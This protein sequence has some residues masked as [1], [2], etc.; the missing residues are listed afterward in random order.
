MGS[1]GRCAH[2]DVPLQ[3]APSEVVGQSGEQYC[4]TGCATL[5]TRLRDQSRE[6]QRLKG[7]VERDSVTGAASKTQLAVVW[8]QVLAYGNP[9]LL[10]LDIDHF[11]Q[12]NDAWGHLVGDEVLSRV[13]LRI[14]GALRPQ[15]A[16]VRYGGDE[17]VVLLANV[18]VREAEMVGER[19]RRTVALNPIAGPN[20]AASVTLSI[21]LAAFPN[22]RA[23]GKCLA[24]WL[25]AADDALYLAKANGRNRVVVAVDPWRSETAARRHG[26]VGDTEPRPCRPGGAT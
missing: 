19:I 1:A 3:D 8:E 24:K 5:E 2:C 4:C 18:D 7:L 11:K 22:A 15:D 10:F 23:A 16:C 21:G 17:F 6:I 9:A 12:I 26:V 20:G 14:C 25:S 13:V